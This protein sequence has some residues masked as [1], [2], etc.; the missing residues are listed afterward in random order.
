MQGS[1]VRA[2]LWSFLPVL[3]PVPE[4]TALGSDVLRDLIGTSRGLPALLLLGCTAVPSQS[5]VTR[6]VDV[7]RCVDASA[8]GREGTR[9]VAQ[10]RSPS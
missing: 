6:L 1:A 3:G 8:L 7:A 4:N 5:V 2:R 10:S 9:R